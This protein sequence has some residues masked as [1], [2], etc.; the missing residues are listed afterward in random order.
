MAYDGVD[1]DDPSPPRLLQGRQQEEGEQG[2][3][4]VVHRSVLLE[5]LSSRLQPPYSASQWEGEEGR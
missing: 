4:Q 3:S 1:V 2:G 5:P